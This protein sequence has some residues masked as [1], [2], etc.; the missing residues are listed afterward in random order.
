M[1]VYLLP[2]ERSR[3]ASLHASARLR[4]GEIDLRLF[5]PAKILGAVDKR[6]DVPGALSTFYRKRIIRT[7]AVQGLGR[8]NSE[9]IKIL[10]PLLPI[11]PLVEYFIGPFLP[12][13]F[14]LQFGYCYSFCPVKMPAAEAR[15]LADRMRER[16]AS[17]AEEAW[18]EAAKE[19]LAIE[20]VDNLHDNLVMTV[21]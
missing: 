10:T 13:V 2:T 5:L 21:K 11:R 12:I 4:D 18:A 17:E 1:F 6:S 20:G 8:M 9:A 14:R 15:Q 3:L 16:H 19:G 7:A